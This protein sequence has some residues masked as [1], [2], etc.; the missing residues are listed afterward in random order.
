METARSQQPA[1]RRPGP[2]D[3]SCRPRILVFT[4]SLATRAPPHQ[5]RPA[6]LRTRPPRLPEATQSISLGPSS[7][8]GLSC[9]SRSLRGRAAAGTTGGGEEE[10]HPSALKVNSITACK[11]LGCS[12]EPAPAGTLPQR[13]ALPQG[14]PHPPARLQAP[15]GSRRPPRKPCGASPSIHLPNSRRPEL[16]PIPPR[17]RIPRAHSA[18]SQ[19]VY[20]SAAVPA[21]TRGG[22]AGARHPAG[23]PP[24]LAAHPEPFYLRQ[25][26]FRTQHRSGVEGRLCASGLS[27]GRV[28]VSRGRGRPT[29]RAA[30]G[31]F[32]GPGRRKPQLLSAFQLARLSAPALL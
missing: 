8:G 19:A 12:P 6:F 23:V 24:S 3:A 29:R 31:P 32:R 2:S 7:L 1:V 18:L 11:L 27:R 13:R 17:H 15:R 22:E 4:L 25:A 14:L 30:G 20:G 5:P 21:G 10:R 9:E 16:N 28:P 26:A